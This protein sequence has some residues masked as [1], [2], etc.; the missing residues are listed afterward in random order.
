MCQHLDRNV[1]QFKMRTKKEK[2]GL[3]PC[4]LSRCF[5]LHCFSSAP[6]HSSVYLWWGETLTE[7]ML[8]NVDWHSIAS[9]PLCFLISSNKLTFSSKVTETDNALRYFSLEF[10]ISS[11]CFSDNQMRLLI[12]RPAKLVCGQRV[13]RI[14][15]D[16]AVIEAL[17]YAG[18][19][20][21]VSKLKTRLCS[22]EPLYLHIIWKQINQDTFRQQVLWYILL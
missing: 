13:D 16:D 22:A 4:H 1:S 19:K 2:A 15:N 11:P 18:S 17:S 12:V 3:A 21:F 20:C 14:R 8:I 7:L 10:S 9:G 5:V 6:P